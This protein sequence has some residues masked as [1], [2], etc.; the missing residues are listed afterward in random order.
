MQAI[1][2]IVLFQSLRPLDSEAQYQN[3]N[4]ASIDEDGTILDRGPLGSGRFLFTYR[5]MHDN[6]KGAAG[7]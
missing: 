3:R 5:D 4:L 1:S 6:E 7:F 2:G